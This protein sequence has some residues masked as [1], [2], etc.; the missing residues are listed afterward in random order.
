[1]PA[2]S[3][4]T[5]QCVALQVAEAH[6]T[7]AD[8]FAMTRTQRAIGHTA[9]RRL[10]VPPALL[11]GACQCADVL[12]FL[13][14]SVVGTAHVARPLAIVIAS[15]AMRLGFG[16]LLPELASAHRDSLPQ[17]ANAQSTKGKSVLGTATALTAGA[18]A[19]VRRTKATGPW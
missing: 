2:G 15:Q 1:M 8:A 6:A 11:V 13:V 19:T 18:P 16:R 3:R 7:M 5:V 4:K 14:S 17:T 9:G 10:R 12:T